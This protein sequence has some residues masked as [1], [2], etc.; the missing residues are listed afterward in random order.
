MDKDKSERTALIMVDFILLNLLAVHALVFSYI[1]YTE[2]FWRE[3]FICVFCQEWN[4]P[5]YYMKMLKM[6]NVFVDFRIIWD[7]N[8]YIQSFI[9]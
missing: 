6:V 8:P 5:I 7:E 4:L 9:L 3:K 2:I 1:Y